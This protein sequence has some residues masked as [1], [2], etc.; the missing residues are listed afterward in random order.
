LG[1]RRLDFLTAVLARLPDRVGY[2]LADT[3]G[4]LHYAFFPR[5]RRAALANVRAMLPNTSAADRRR[6]VRGM[7]TSYVRMLFEFFRLP[8]LT[9]E[10]R[11]AA[12]EVVGMENVRAALE[13]GRGVV[14][15]SCHIGNWELGAVVVARD[16][17]PV[18]AVAGVQFGR[19][20]AGDVREAKA[21]LAVATISPEDGFRKIWRALSRNE[22][23]ALMV[24]G[25]VYSQ[26]V[27]CPFFGRKVEWPS[28]PG[29]LAKR[30]R[31]PVVAGY[32]ERL[33]PGRFRVC[34]EPALDPDAF[35]DAHALNAAIAAVTEAHIRPRIEQW[36]IFR[37][38]W[39]TASDAHTANAVAERVS[40]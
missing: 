17:H 13:L 6:M 23:V 8:A 11:D 29:S 34:L 10:R 18:N 31:S 30:T 1:D 40:T 37:P 2:A 24:D 7:M 36:C 25:D 9:P 5:R 3:L 39:P 35:A 27:E 15:T 22:I 14:L 28:G 38:L 12:I 20:L 32:C 16:S 21:Q 33:G 26:G 4:V 19:W